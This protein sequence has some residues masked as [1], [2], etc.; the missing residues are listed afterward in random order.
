MHGTFLPGTVSILKRLPM[1]QASI[2]KGLAV[3]LYTLVDSFSLLKKERFVG[4]YILTF[5]LKEDS[6]S[7]PSISKWPCSKLLRG[8]KPKLWLNSFNIAL[9]MIPKAGRMCLTLQGL[10]APV[11]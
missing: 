11:C 9:V 2:S 3:T 1:L 8:R 7:F 4:I 10:S 6:P 5:L